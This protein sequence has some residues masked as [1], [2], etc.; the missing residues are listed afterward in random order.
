M[1]RGTRRTGLGL[2]TPVGRMTGFTPL[3]YGARGAKRA[4]LETGAL[5]ARGA[6]LKVEKRGTEET[7]LTLGAE[8][9]RG[10]GLKAQEKQQKLKKDIKKKKRLLRLK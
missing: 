10:A 7:L 5:G 6:D 1:T 8:G 9:A 3:G 4:F 2:L